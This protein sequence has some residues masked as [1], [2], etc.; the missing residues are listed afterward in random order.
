MIEENGRN[1]IELSWLQSAELIGKK[2]SENSEFQSDSIAAIYGALFKCHLNIDQNCWFYRT[3][4]KSIDMSVLIRES[5]R[6]II[7][8]A[9]NRYW[10]KRKFWLENIY[11]LGLFYRL[12]CI[13]YFVYYVTWMCQLP[14]AKVPNVT[15]D[16]H[17]LSTTISM[18]LDYCL[19]IS[20]AK[21]LFLQC[22]GIIL[23]CGMLGGIF[24]RGNKWRWLRAAAGRCLFLLQAPIT[25][26]VTVTVT[27][28]N[29]SPSSARSFFK[30]FHFDM[31]MRN[32][33]WSIHP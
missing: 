16:R 32:W 21:L 17:I 3:E 24:S 9:R 25:C 8:A 13:R 10:I 22:L 18:R 2:K 28:C 4:L 29:H 27:N 30:H 6:W 26:F 31:S 12:I 7:I 15:K 23:G 11:W 20:P 14:I 19:E 33:N 5:E 1:S